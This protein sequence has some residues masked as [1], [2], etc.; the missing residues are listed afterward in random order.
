[1]RVAEIIR[2][3]AI[4][5]CSA[6]ALLL[7]LAPVAA[8]KRV[9]LVIGNATYSKVGTLKNPAQ[10]A[11]AM[12]SLFKSAG[13]QVVEQHDLGISALRQAIGDFAD[14]SADADVAVVYYAGHGIEVDGTNYLIPVD[15]KLARDFDAPLA[16]LRAPSTRYGRERCTADPG[17]L[18]TPN[19]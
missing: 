3:A 8:E 1:M 4:V 11:I 19:S 5:L 15:A 10:D 18:Q 12:A 13:F 16:R 7:G 9:A 17:P 2:F 6:A 14:L